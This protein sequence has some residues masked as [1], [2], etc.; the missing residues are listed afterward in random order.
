[1]MSRDVPY[2]ISPV[3]R[4]PPEAL[5]MSRSLWLRALACLSVT[6]VLAAAPIPRATPS[7]AASYDDLLALF[8]D[9]R[10]FQTPKLI[11]GVPDYSARA[12]AAQQHELSKYQARLAAIDTAGWPIPQRI[13]HILVRAE[14]NGLDF[15]QRV[16]KPWARSPAFYVMFYPSRS[17]QPLREGP[18]IS[19]SIE[20]WM[21]QPFTPER[22]AALDARLRTIPAVLAQAKTNLTENSHDFWVLG[23]REMQAQSKALATFAQQNA[24]SNPTLSPDAQ[25]AAEATDQFVAWLQQ[26]LPSKT[27]PSGIGVDNYNWYLKNVEMVPYTWA[28]EVALLSSELGRTTTAMRLEEEHDKD[29]PPFKPIANAEDYKPIFDAAVTDYLNGLRK[30][31]VLTIKDYMEPALR[32]RGHYK[33]LDQF[34][35]FNQV[36]DR[37]PILMLAHDFHWF[38]LAQIQY[39]PNPD[40]IRRDG[41]LYNIFDSRTEGFA[42]GNEELMTNVGTYE[43]HP[44]IRELMNA[45]AAERCAVAMGDLKMASSEWNV[46]KAV[47]YAAA[48]TPHGWLS[49]QSRNVWGADGEGLYLEQPTYG[50]SYTIGKI[51]IMRLIADRVQQQGDAFTLKGFLDEFTSVGLIPVALIRWQMTGKADEVNW[52]AG[53]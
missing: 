10:T 42:S 2:R 27:G 18:H 40:P 33:G 51:E 3:A 52:M 12:M 30:H 15:D 53:R 6:V 23:I 45:V 4:I 13:D 14:M 31:D 11:D 41:L 37:D 5:L 8:R 1:M 49:T 26:Q 7:H 46:D 16:K 36:S 35:F 24:T 20:L 25:R 38:D 9:W 29:L 21:F 43:G 19:T 47:Q 48:Y 44:R 39:D 50:T 32:A 34:E 22:V 28:D 17:D